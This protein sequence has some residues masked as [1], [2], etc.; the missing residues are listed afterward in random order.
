MERFSFCKGYAFLFRES[1][2]YRV[3]SFRG[4]CFTFKRRLHL[5]ERVLFLDAVVPLLGVR[6]SFLIG[7]HFTSRWKV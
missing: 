5:R 1:F 3:A 4:E 6:I 2:M 7:G